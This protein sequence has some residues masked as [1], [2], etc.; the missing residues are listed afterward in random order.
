MAAYHFQAI[1]EPDLS[2]VAVFLREQQEITSREDPTQARPGSDNLRW[3]LNNPHRR[4]GI[5]L[6]ET[7]RSEDGRILGMILAIPRMY[8]IGDKQSLGL[9]AG[10]FYVDSSARMQGFFILRRFLSIKGVDFWYA[11]SCNRQSGPL[12]AK[13]GAGQ[14]PESD[15]EYILPFRLGPIIQELSLR[16]GWP[17]PVIRLLGLLGPAA[18]LVSAPRLPKK[19]FKIDYCV[20][21]DRLSELSERFRK[22]DLLQPE[23]SRAYLDWVY[24]GLP[25][26]PGDNQKLATYT[27]I[28][29]A[30]VEG[31]FSLVF[32]PRGGL[33][34]IRSARLVDVVWPETRMSFA[35]VLPAVTQAARVRSDL[36]SIRGRVGLGLQDRMMGLRRRTLLAPEGFLLS[37]SP[38]TSDLVPQ[39]DFPFADRY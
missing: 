23:R 7:L 25:T 39:A 13:C 14:V 5:P 21:L 6:G 19:R 17:L 38:S 11:N 3:L 30:G 9:A 29:N 27:F 22:P 20:D 26:T 2:E 15:V 16:K 12:W 8:R 32:E 18:T 31:W 36:L 28:D 33:Q 35:E 1:D 10:N 34:Q 37:R 24:G 4:E